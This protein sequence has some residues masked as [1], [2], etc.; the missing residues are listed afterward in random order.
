MLGR[1][2]RSCA[3]VL[4]LHVHCDA[5]ASGFAK[6]AGKKEAHEATIKTAKGLGA[7]AWR[8]LNDDRFAEAAKREYEEHRK[9]ERPEYTAA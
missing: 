5:V 6:A 7:V 8:I 9:P 3:A 2:S 1:N 4:I